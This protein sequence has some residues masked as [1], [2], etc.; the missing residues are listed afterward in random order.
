MILLSLQLVLTRIPG[1]LSKQLCNLSSWQLLLQVFPDE[2]HL[3]T[4]N[5]FL[6]SCAELHQNVNVK[7]III[8]LIDRLAMFAQRGNG[9]GVP[10]DI[11]LFE[12]FSQQVSNVPQGEGSDNADIRLFEI[13]SQQVAHVIQVLLFDLV[14]YLI[15]LLN[16]PAF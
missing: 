10:E 6:K 3:Q 7:N 11:K 12:I 9:S 5:A 16:A 14:Y 8:A 15:F 2:F 4:L 13:F 1:F